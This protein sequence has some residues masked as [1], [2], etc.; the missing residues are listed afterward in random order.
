MERK[1]IYG[2]LVASATLMF[3][4]ASVQATDYTWDG[5]GANSNWTNNDNW[6]GDS[7]HP[8]G[9]ADKAIFTSDATVTLDSNVTVGA[10]ELQ[11]SGTDV[12]LSNSSSRKRLDLTGVNSNAGQTG[13]MI[14]PS[15]TTFDVGQ[16]VT[17]SLKNIDSGEEWQIGGVLTMSYS[18]GSSGNDESRIRVQADLILGPHSS[19]YGFLDGSD[20]DDDARLQIDVPS[21]GETR[22][23]NKITVSGAMII[24][25]NGS[26]DGDVAFENK[27]VAT[28]ANSG[29][30]KADVP[31]GILELASGLHVFDEEVEISSV[32]YYPLWAADGSG[33]VL[34]FATEAGQ[35]PDDFLV[36]DFDLKN[37]ADLDIDQDV[38]T[39]G[40]L[41]QAMGTSVTVAVGKCF[42]YDTLSSI[43]N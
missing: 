27:R 34:R 36:G 38:S 22:V 9:A 11:N 10:V 3:G 32:F 24:E 20:N 6:V 12:S 7:G 19:S 40:S 26:G 30:V 8:S 15:G 25:P 35:S 2:V 18:D 39:D 5:G 13:Q 33:A 43:C 14:I 28:D 31:G 16:N 41:T 17:L 42:F 37:S 4:A 1:R 29:V 23:I 21:S